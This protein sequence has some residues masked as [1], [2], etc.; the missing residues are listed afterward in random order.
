MRVEDYRRRVGRVP[1]ERLLGGIQ[2]P[3]H[4]CADLRE[5]AKVNSPT[6]DNTCDDIMI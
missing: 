4:R 1:V 3:P 6:N 5:P 2:D